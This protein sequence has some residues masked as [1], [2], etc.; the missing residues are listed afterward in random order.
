[1]LIT[2]RALFSPFPPRYDLFAAL[3]MLEQNRRWRAAMV[4]PAPRPAA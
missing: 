2:T 1:M 4:D 3:R